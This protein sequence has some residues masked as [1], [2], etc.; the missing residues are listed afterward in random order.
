MFKKGDRVRIKAGSVIE[1]TGDRN[2]GVAK[3]ARVVTVICFDE[4]VTP[5]EMDLRFYPD[6]QPRLAKVQWAGSGSYW[7]WTDASNCEL[8]S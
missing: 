6:I 5:S 4:A 8:V 3:R 1:S 7:C 2:K